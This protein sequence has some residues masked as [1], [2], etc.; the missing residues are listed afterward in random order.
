[1]LADLAAMSARTV[2]QLAAII[3]SVPTAIVMV[4]PR[5]TIDLANAQAERLFKY[6]RAE[7]IGESVE[8]LV[9]HRFRGGHPALRKSFHERPSARR[10]GA[11]RDLFGLRKDGT[12]FPIEIGL[13]PIETDEGLYVVSAIVDITDRKRMEARFRGMVESAPTAM[14]MVDHDGMIVVVNAELERLFGYGREELLH[15]KVEALLPKRFS[16]S[17]PALRAGY[18]SSPRA[19]PMGVGRDLAGLRK[20]GTEF[21][22]EIGLNPIETDEGVFVLGAV[23]DISERTRQ[24]EWLQQSHEALERSNIDLQRFAYIASHDLQTPMRSIASFV[25]LLGSTYG[26]RLD[27]QGR[28]WLRRTTESITHL[29]TMVRD[30]L[31]YSRVDS[32]AHPFQRISFRDVV[33]RAILLLDA[34]IGESG[35]TITIGE[36]PEV[37]GEIA[38]LV[39]LMLNLIGNAIKYRTREPPHV[40]VSAERRGDDWIFAVGDN[41]IGIAPK[42]HERIFDL[43]KRLHEAKEY[44]GN[45]IGL[46]V[47]RRIVS[48]HGGKIWVESESGKGSVFY[49]TVAEGPAGRG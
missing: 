39:Q 12:E 29:Q 16:A 13:N 24:A 34:S 41:G 35:A 40:R 43:F 4:D 47:S 31:D 1:M 49:F 6:A 14:L 30:L 5:G 11:G 8:M 38:Q 48:R 21:P 7:L 19:R 23:V 42:H 44:P 3:D 22:I 33:D 27:A 10:M 17:H 36:L 32:G 45:G 18:V 20:D 26:D 37:T 25:E 28:D 2:A 9:P 15:K 46:A